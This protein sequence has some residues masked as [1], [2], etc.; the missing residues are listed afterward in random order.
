ML[1]VSIGLVIDNRCVCRYSDSLLAEWSGDGIPVGARLFAPVYSGPEVSYTV[2]TGSLPGIKRP[3]LGV[4]HSPT[5]P[6]LAR[7][8]KKCNC[9]F[10]TPSIPSWQIIRWTL[11]MGRDSSVD[12]AIRYGLDDPVIESRWGKIFNTRPYRPWG[13]PSVLYVGSRVLPGV[14]AA[15]AWLWLPTSS[16]AWVKKTL[17]LYLYSPSGPS[18]PVTGWTYLYLLLSFILS[19]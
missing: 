8:L 10:T 16:S 11:S 9:N 1:F 5:H 4:N 14:K 13:S 12:I 19:Y 18:W 7:P 17:E 3:G 15:G 6:R 2:G